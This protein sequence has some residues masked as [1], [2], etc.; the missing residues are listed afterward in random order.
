MN[1]FVS[2]VLW[3]SY[4]LSLYFAVFLLL[5]YFDKKT[6]FMKE[7]TET[8]LRSYPFVSILVPAYNEEKT[9]EKTLRSIQQI[10]YPHDHFEVFVINDGST[11]RTEETIKT[12]IVD[13]PHFTLLSHPNRG[14]AA[15]L[16]RALALAQGEFFAC[17]DADS[18]V[19]PLTLRKMLAS[20][21]K[22]DDPRVA[23]ITP[24]MKVAEPK[25]V[26]QKIQWLE[27]LVM[28]LFSRITA[29]L[30]SLY[31]APGPFSIYRTEIIRDLGGFDEKNITEDQEIAYR[32]QLQQYKIKQCFDGYVYTT[33]PAK[34]KPFYR[35]RRRWYLGSIACLHQYREMI[36]NRKYGDFGVMQMAKN[37]VGYFLAVAGITI[38]LYY[39]FLPV[40]RF[41]GKMNA[42]HFDLLNYA[43]HYQTHV[44][45]FTF[46]LLDFRLLFF[47]ILLSLIG[48][49]FFSAAHRNAHETINKW[50]W[51][52]IIPYFF[53]Y[54]LLKGTILLISL[55]RFSWSKKIRW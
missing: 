50:G 20:Y 10:D 12:F 14:K 9:I 27:Y 35:Q 33:A 44:N 53:G 26:L 40:A 42:I 29:T 54:Y 32:V 22:E 36:A 18:F 24:A 31:V 3:I 48:V 8:T 15:S 6:V 41:L 38:S 46:L 23:I 28:I 39:L 37:T 16:N 30:H 47:L 19:H 43:A 49:I 13:K 55:S 1:L 2:I 21:Q 52:P 4:V 17:L 11:D 34:L 45:I 25:T 51:F 5:V 7:K